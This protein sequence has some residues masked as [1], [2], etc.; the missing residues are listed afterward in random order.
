MVRIIISGDVQGVGFRQYIRYK[1]RKLNIKGWVRNLPASGQDG[2]GE[3]V[4]A[5][6]C[7]SKE[8]VKKMIEI[9]RH[10]PFLAN[11]KSIDVEEVPD[12]KF[13][14]FKILK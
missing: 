8:N 13:E 7:G 14:D 4:E 10:G 2:F 9:S 11:V 3:K 6:F 12:Q 5:N 1:A